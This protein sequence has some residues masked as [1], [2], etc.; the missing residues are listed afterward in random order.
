MPIDVPD[1]ARSRARSL[2]ERGE[3][4]LTGLPDLVAAEER[5]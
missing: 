2:G 3:R 4:W 5:E 1:L